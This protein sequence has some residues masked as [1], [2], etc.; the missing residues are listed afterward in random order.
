MLRPRASSPSSGQRRLSLELAARQAV[1]AT[2]S[3]TDSSSRRRAPRS[4]S[5][6]HHPLETT[7]DVE[8]NEHPGLPD[9]DELL[10]GLE[11]RER[12][13]GHRDWR[14]RGGTA[15]ATGACWRR[16]YY[17]CAPTARVEHVDVRDVELNPRAGALGNGFWLG[18]DLQRGR[19][20][21]T[22]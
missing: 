21:A 14:R 16:C 6:R 7:R 13:V 20:S 2:G 8:L 22:S 19:S 9:P 1:R 15:R 17:R 12:P 18:V 3:A 11:G 10:L 4:A 5:D